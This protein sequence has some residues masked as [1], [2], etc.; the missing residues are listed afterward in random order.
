MK[1]L[2][3][4][5]YFIC[6]YLF[7]L[8]PGKRQPFVQRFLHI[9]IPE[10]PFV[11]KMRCLFI[12]EWYSKANQ[13]VPILPHHIPDKIIFPDCKIQ[14]R[15]LYPIFQILSGMLSNIKLRI[16]QLSRIIKGTIHLRHPDLVKALHKIFAVQAAANPSG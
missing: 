16:C 9:L 8:P 13:F 12:V 15:K 3:S 7:F 1:H 5:Q 6:H 10:I 14:F 2:L 11:A 4:P